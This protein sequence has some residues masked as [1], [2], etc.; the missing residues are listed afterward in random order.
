[1]L[2]LLALLASLWSPAQ[3][4]NFIQLPACGNT[5]PP[6]IRPSAPTITMNPSGQVCIA[7]SFSAT[8][9]TPTVVIPS[10]LTITIY[11][12]QVVSGAFADGALV[13]L[14]QVGEAAYKTVNT[15]GDVIAL[16]KGIFANVMTPISVTGGTGG[17]TTTVN[18]NSITPT[19]LN[20][21]VASSPLNV[22]GSF[23]TSVASPIGVNIAATTPINVTVGNGNA[24]GQAT[25]ANSSPVVLPSD[26]TPLNVTLAASPLNVTG[27]LTAN[28]SSPIAVNIASSPVNVTGNFTTGTPLNVTISASPASTIVNNVNPNGLATMANSS[29]VVI[30]SDQTPVSVNIATASSPI[31]VTG[32]FSTGASPQSVVVVNTASPQTVTISG[33]PINVTQSQTPQNVTLA[34]SPLNV[35]VGGIVSPQGVTITSSPVNVTATVASPVGVNIAS[36]PVNVSIVG[37]PQNVTLAGPTPLNM[38]LVAIPGTPINV[39]QSQSPQNVTIASSP[40]N[41][42]VGS[43]ENV[44]VSNGNP[45]GL[46]TS[47]SS[48]PVV[49]ASD[50]NVRVFTSLPT[51]NAIIAH[52]VT[53]AYSV[54]NAV[55]ALGVTPGLTPSS[56]QLV[57]AWCQTRTPVVTPPVMFLQLFSSSVTETT[58]GTTRPQAVVAIAGSPITIGALP[59]VPAPGLAFT[60]LS[61]AV[62]QSPTNSNA[63]GAFVDCS[64][65]YN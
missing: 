1:M 40:L 32:T 4:Q 43:P 5:L 64:F 6:S 61:F 60:A 45:N 63:T 44:T 39:T 26:Q 19:P 37:S 33:T 14:G 35:T 21:T 59:P 16:L 7:G 10:P 58:I 13:T 8:V 62:A 28:V 30:A 23:S 17:S 53:T 25:K 54:T 29:P 12:S 11:P 48:S 47:A 3:A 42:T 27:S 34:A 9:P 20:V 41:V 57:Q 15:S 46:A 56:K 22:T 49:V 55:V 65:V 31:N 36:S 51:A 52:K 24:N 50:S 18:I 38:T 2:K